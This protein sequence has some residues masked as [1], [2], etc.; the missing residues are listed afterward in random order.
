MMAAWGHNQ[1]GNRGD[2]LVSSSALKENRS[3][4]PGRPGAT[5]QGSH[6]EATFIDKHPVGVQ[7]TG[8]FLI[9]IQ[10]TLTHVRMRFSSRST[11]RRSGFWG[12]HP[13]EWIK[14]EM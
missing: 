14:R 9:R 12:D 10:S 2:F 8:F 5:H 13:K 1:G 3:V 11:E 7:A 4:S 6:Q